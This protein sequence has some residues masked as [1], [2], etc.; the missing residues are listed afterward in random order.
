[1]NPEHSFFRRYILLI[2]IGGIVLVAVFLNWT[3]NIMKLE[4]KEINIAPKFQAFYKY[5][6]LAYLPS[7][8][9]VAG[10]DGQ[11]VGLRDFRGKF[12][13]L[14]V[15]AT[16]CPPCIQNLS[17]L[18]MLEKYLHGKGWDVIAISIDNRADIQKL[19][20]F[21]HKN[22]IEDLAGYYDVH[23]A[24][25]QD[26]HTEK[27][28]ITYIINRN[29]RLLYEVRGAAAWDDEDVVDFLNQVRATL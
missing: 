14:N 21:V 17:R 9:R 28:P 29:G 1:M 8:I 18:Q 27:L 22:R 12:L 7:T 13:V 20:A 23:G 4:R 16:W 10:P 6:D 11:E 2:G 5:D 3:F 25:R 19:A 26:M 24:L 15:W